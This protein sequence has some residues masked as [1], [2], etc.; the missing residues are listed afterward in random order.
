MYITDTGGQPEFQELLPILVSGPSLFFLTFRLDIELNRRYRVEYIDSKGKSII[1]YESS[2]T[3][4]EMLLQSLATIASTSIFRIV[5][6]ERVAI[7]PNAFLVGT[8]R[9][10]VSDE[11]LQQ[12]DSVLQALVRG[13]EAFREGMIQFASES[14]LILAVNNLSEGE[15][16]VQQIRA[17]VERIGK[18]GENYRV[19]TPFSWLM[20][21][22]I[23]QQMRS[24]I[25][26]YEQCFNLA[27]LTVCFC[28]ISK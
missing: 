3:V 13:T 11:H 15:E 28:F 9:D 14:R 5:G 6:S 27:L 23:M 10:L 7:N 22:N 26:K 18:Q 25:L 2:L 1:P 12:V 20:F 8:H 16:D 21:S 4:Q 17:A 24:P 19:R